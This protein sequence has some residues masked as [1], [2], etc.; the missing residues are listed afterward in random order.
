MIFKDEVKNMQELIEKIKNIS[1]L[2]KIKVG[3]VCFIFDE[4]G[5]L[6]LSRRGPGARDEIG[7]LQAIGGSINKSDLNFRSAVIR[8]IMEE[9]GTEANVEID[10]F[11]GAQIDTKMDKHTN[12]LTSW[13]ILAYKGILKSGKL[14]NMEPDRCIG[15]EY[16][17]MDHFK[18]ED[19]SETAYKFIQELKKM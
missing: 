2:S 13:V 5:K 8:E 18:K 3:V 15:F 11:I 6:I 16:E 10:K 9:A 14:N 17:Y 1:G 7:K 12:E 4:N 19:L